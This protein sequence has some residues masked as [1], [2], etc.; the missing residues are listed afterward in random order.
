VDHPGEGE[1]GD[2]I[3]EVASKEERKDRGTEAMLAIGFARGRSCPLPPRLGVDGS[4]RRFSQSSLIDEIRN[5]IL[6][7]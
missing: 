5:K 1:E 2:L 6:E 3:K 7:F 4:M